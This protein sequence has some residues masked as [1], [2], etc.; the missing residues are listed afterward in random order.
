MYTNPGG[1][2]PPE[3]N[4]NA[5]TSSYYE[6]DVAIAKHKAAAKHLNSEAAAKHLSSGAT[7]YLRPSGATAKD[8]NSGTTHYLSPSGASSS[9]AHAD[10]VIEEDTYEELGERAPPGPYTGLNLKQQENQEVIYE[11]PKGDTQD[12]YINVPRKV[13][14]NGIV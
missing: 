10:K 2:T 4:G 1:P 7:H 9:E 8:L 3:Q 13:S 14:V 6:D 11:L 12:E 5:A